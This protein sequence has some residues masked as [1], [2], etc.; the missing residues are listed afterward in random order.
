[1]QNPIA[2]ALGDEKW[3]NPRLARPNPH[4]GAPLHPVGTKT[5]QHPASWTFHPEAIDR[6][7]RCI[8]PG[9]V[10]GTRKTLCPVVGPAVPGSACD[11]EQGG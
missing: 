2:S 5:Q 9:I 10:I 3:A 7:S 6:D 8:G 11:S 1:M 4:L